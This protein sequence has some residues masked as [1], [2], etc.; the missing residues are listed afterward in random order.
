MPRHLFHQTVH[1]Q[2]GENRFFF[3][4]SPAQMNSF[5]TDCLNLAPIRSKIDVI[6]LKLKELAQ[7]KDKSQSE[8]QAANATLDAIKSSQGSLGQEP[9][10]NVTDAVVE[11]LKAQL[12]QAQATLEALKGAHKARKRSF[13]SQ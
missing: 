8:L 11:G 12:A 7:G 4:Q 6:D 1:R 13:S 10:T 2:Q 5:L 9:T 3:Q